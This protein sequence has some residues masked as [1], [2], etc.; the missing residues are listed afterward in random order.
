[1]VSKSLFWKIPGNQTRLFKPPTC[2]PTG[3]AP[4]APTAHRWC[5][6]PGPA[7][8]GRGVS[9]G[10]GWYKIDTP[11]KFKDGVTW[12]SATGKGSSYWKHIILRFQPLN[13]G[14]WFS[15]QW[16]SDKKPTTSKASLCGRWFLEPESLASWESMHEHMTTSSWR[17]DSTHLQKILFVKM[18]SSS[19][20]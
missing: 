19:Q 10:V 4:G 6:P 15:H 2:S 20:K 9:A 16:K 17:F 5:D 8:I 7:D 11:M 14:G 3:G 18:G 13:F 12:K 1:M